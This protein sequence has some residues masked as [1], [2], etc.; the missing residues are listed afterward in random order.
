MFAASLPEATYPVPIAICSKEDGNTVLSNT[1][2]LEMRVKREKIVKI[3]AVN[4]HGR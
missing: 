3:E 4:L 1:A 2:R